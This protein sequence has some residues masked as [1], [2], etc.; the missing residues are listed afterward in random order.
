MVTV[1]G[2]TSS[3]AQAKGHVAVNRLK[4]NHINVSFDHAAVLYPPP[5][6]QP[7]ISAR[8]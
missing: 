5:P 4:S 3:S 1:L 7:R 8:R 2:V 6:L